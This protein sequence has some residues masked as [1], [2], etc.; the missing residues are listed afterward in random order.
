LRIL[1]TGASSEMG[2]R[3][4]RRLKDEPRLA[5]ATYLLL[6]HQKP[7]DAAPGDQVLDSS[8]L[9]LAPLPPLDAVIHLAGLSHS[10]DV[11]A[12]ERVNLGGT[13]RLLEAVDAKS[14]KQF[15]YMSSRCL[16][17]AGGAY[18]RS[19]TLAEQAIRESGLPWTIF[20]P[21]EV[22]GE[23]YGWGLTRFVDL[24]RRWGIFPVIFSTAPVTLAPVSL[25]DTVEAVARSLLNP[26]CAG[27]TYTLAG[28]RDY[29]F[30]EIWRLVGASL[31]RRVWPLPVP[32]AI[33][34]A[35]CAVNAS[36]PIFGSLAPD[37]IDRL[38]VKKSS[39]SSDAIRD[40]GFQPRALEE[41][42][43]G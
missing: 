38:L 32:V 4:Y 43:R 33:L 1:L 27:K 22:I 6:R 19:K 7:I 14:L 10:M 20:R 29:R 26:L 41:I 8:V 21:A 28:P 13:K 35:A 23:Q 11:E 37:Q 16:G 15:V 34:R 25:S 12:Y 42:L 9:N 30:A 40:L 5:G 17:E 18:S 2:R 39:D 3:L 24:A 31:P 36:C